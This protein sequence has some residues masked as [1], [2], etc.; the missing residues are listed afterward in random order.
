MS[1]PVR[2]FARA[3]D[4]LVPLGAAVFAIV[5]ARWA[6]LPGIWFWD[7]AEAQTVPPLLGVMHPTGFPAYV[8]LGWVASAVLEPFGE[9]AFRMNLL[10]G[11]LIGVAAAGVVS[12]ARRLDVPSVIAL[13]AGIGFAATPLPWR[14]GTH[15]DVHALH[16]ALLALLLIVL[17]AWGRDARDPAAPAGS[18]DG[19]LVLGAAIYGVSLGNHQLT[20]L[21]A[22]PVVL[23][24]LAVDASVF[25]R[26]RTIAAA[27]VAALGVPVLLY[28]QL[29]LR[30]GPF[31]APIVYGRPDTLEGLRYVILAE[32]FRGSLYNPLLDPGGALG[33]LAGRAWQQFG[34][35]A[36]LVPIAF[37]VTAV[38]HPRYALLS[39][40]AAGITLTF[41][42]AYVNADIERYDLGPVLMSWTWLAVLARELAAAPT[43]VLARAGPA[44]AGPGPTRLAPAAR[45]GM[46]AIVA[47][48]LLAPV[49]TAIPDRYRVV[50]RSTDREAEVWLDTVMRV[51]ERDAVVVSWWS[52]STPLWY[53]QL[54]EGRRP[55]VTVIDDRTRLDERLGGVTDVI[56]ANLGKRPV[57]VIR[58][59]PAELEALERRYVL[60]LV[61]ETDVLF[62]VVASRSLA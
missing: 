56:D 54:I 14:M 20:L 13:A 60:E 41:N 43:T 17:V 58:A 23:Y 5:L 11:L 25:R 27:A 16:V 39:G 26:R 51:L 10:S 52:Y 44:R 46:A 2:S 15:A 22:L 57:Y 3:L 36:V 31:P 1:L 7:T 8:L 9:P 37:V 59:F 38:R 18:A 34:I 24:V 53:G 33:A 35:L 12:L 40:T 4:R 19:L 61:P 32:Q 50:D 29:P 47:V 45:S 21:L 6:M 30:A 55:D 48:A 42:A 49:I 62:R 28:L